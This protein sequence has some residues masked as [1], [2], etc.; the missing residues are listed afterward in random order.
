[1][2][3]VE[4]RGGL[5]NQLFQYAT[6]RALSLR[7]NASLYLDPSPLASTTETGPIEARDLLLTRFPIQAT[8]L[9]PT[10]TRTVLR[11]V[12]HK[13][14]KVLDAVHPALSISLLRMFT[15]TEGLKYNPTVMDLPPEV[16]LRGYFQSEK[17]FFRI[18]E[19][20]LDEIDWPTGHTP[21]ENDWVN[22]M[23]AS[24]S[25]SVHVR[26]GDY[27]QLGWTL[28]AAYYRKAL[29]VQMERHADVRVFFFSDNISWVQAHLGD[30]LP[31]EL[32][33]K[34]VALVSGASEGGACEEML[35][36]KE[37]SHHVISSS[38]FSWWGAWLNRNDQKTVVTPKYWVRD[39]VDNLDIVPARWLSIS[40]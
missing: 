23:H 2:P 30:L 6:G 25:V 29:Q 16:R 1:M 33:R 15:E 17:Y 39:D 27:T 12:Q 36:M 22:R 24:T 31:N 9:D 28:P 11:T 26:R 3:V 10:P 19:Q 8:T 18:R 21:K 37:C 35:M 40:W 13:A 14:H 38:T 5:G 7:T 20:L 34:Q 32:P 4:L